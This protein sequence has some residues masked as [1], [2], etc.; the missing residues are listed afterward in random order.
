MGFEF[1]FDNP[2]I[3]II[4]IAALSSL[5]KKK[6]KSAENQ[7]TAYPS[8]GNQQTK[9][10]SPFEEVKE[11]FKEVTRSFSEDTMTPDRRAEKPVIQQKT[12]EI[13]QQ[14]A[15]REQVTPEEKQPLPTQEKTRSKELEM[16]QQK[17][18]DAIIWSEVLGPPRAKKPYMKSRYRN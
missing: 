12:E 17:L 3:F 4:L 11:I 1:F 16:D 10:V 5:F 6:K 7:R 15:L 14:T 2:F 13:Y 9:P 18:V 8:K